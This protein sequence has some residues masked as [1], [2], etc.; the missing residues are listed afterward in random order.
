MRCRTSRMGKRCGKYN[1]ETPR[2]SR[3]ESPEAPTWR[4]NPSLVEDAVDG[5][6]EKLCDDLGRAFK[7][8]GGGGRVAS[9]VL[10]VV[11][12]KRSFEFA[13]RGSDL[14]TQR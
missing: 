14:A 3:S 7:R 13:M 8:D 1:A 4:I 9:H 6:V 11:D 12:M 2:L 5:I 10:V